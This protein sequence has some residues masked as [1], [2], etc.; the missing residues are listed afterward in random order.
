MKEGMEK[1]RIEGRMI[2]GSPEYK[3]R[4]GSIFRSGLLF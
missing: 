1:E 2:K 4:L 3:K